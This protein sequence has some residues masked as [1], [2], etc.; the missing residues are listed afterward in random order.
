LIADLILPFV[1]DRAT[2]NTVCSAS[3]ELRRA[4]KKMTPPWPNKVFNLLGHSVDRVR[5]SP[6]GSQPHQS[7]PIRCSCLGSMGRGN[8][9]WGSHQSNKLL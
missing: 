8:A 6:S 2:W 9:P 5:F 1:A 4:G 3:N 7:R